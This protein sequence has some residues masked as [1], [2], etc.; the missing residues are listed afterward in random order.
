MALTF[1][2]LL[3]ACLLM[4]NA[5]AV[6]HEERFLAKGICSYYL[7]QVLVCISVYLSFINH[8]IIEFNPPF[9]SSKWE[10]SLLVFKIT[11]ETPITQGKCTLYM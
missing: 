8:E 6:L 11:A 4:V 2:S 1:Y 5:V 10:F 3:E 9:L 7:I